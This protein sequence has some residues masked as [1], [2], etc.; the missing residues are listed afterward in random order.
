MQL[1]PGDVNQYEDEV[2]MAKF[3]QRQCSMGLIFLPNVEGDY[4][5]TLALGL[6]QNIWN[7]GKAV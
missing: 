4:C 7:G 2:I 6:Q 3:K 1:F 5:M